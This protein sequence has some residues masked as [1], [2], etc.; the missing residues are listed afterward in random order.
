MNLYD[1]ILFLVDC[2]QPNLIGDGYCNDEVNIFDCDYDGGD[3]C[4]S[5]INTDLCTNCSCLGGIIGNGV[6]NVLVG[7]GHCNDETNN[8]YCLYDG[9]DCCR[10]HIDATFCSDCSCHGEAINMQ[11]LFLLWSDIFNF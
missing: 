7:D 11:K 8:I 2:N 6:P 1:S 10:S 4:G 5:C 3:C 9:L